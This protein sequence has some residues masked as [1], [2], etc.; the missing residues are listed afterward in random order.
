MLA[1]PLD[2]RLSTAISLRTCTFQSAPRSMDN[3]EKAAHHML[4]ALHEAL[5]DDLAGV[6][7]AALDVDR[8]LHDRV[9]PAAERLSGAVL[10]GA[11][12]SASLR[13]HG[14]VLTWQGTVA[15]MAGVARG[16]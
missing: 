10:S 9:R 6:V 5:V 13:R 14:R 12:R 8:L 16:A 2:T 4:A 1:W 11:S 3:Q 7:L 15:G